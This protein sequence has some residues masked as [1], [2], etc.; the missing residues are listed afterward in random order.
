MTPVSAPTADPGVAGPDASWALISADPR[1]QEAVRKPAL[2]HHR[3]PGWPA[4]HHRRRSPLQRPPLGS[5]NHH[6][7]PLTCALTLP[8]SGSPAADLS[9]ARRLLVVCPRAGSS[10]ARSP[11]SARA[12]SSQR[13]R[14]S[15]AR[16][17]R[18]R[19]AKPHS[20]LLL[21]SISSKRVSREPQCVIYAP[22]RKSYKQERGGY[23]PPWDSNDDTD[24]EWCHQADPSENGS[25]RGDHVTA[26][27]ALVRVIDRCTTENDGQDTADNRECRDT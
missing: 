10:P 14:R 18:W 12:R 11:N 23:S 24:D 6:P 9:L 3:N 20:V 7:R 27:A 19:A 21:G 1:G 15:A 26:L 17:A 2:T 5:R 8:N 13:A 16:L 4:H 25:N 22:G